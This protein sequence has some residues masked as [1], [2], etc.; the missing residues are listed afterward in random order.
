MNSHLTASNYARKANAMSL[1][2]V[3]AAQNFMRRATDQEHL[4]TTTKTM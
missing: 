4:P 1:E 2:R 3:L